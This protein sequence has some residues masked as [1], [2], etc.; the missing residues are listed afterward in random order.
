MPETT[1]KR[2]WSHLVWKK[3]ISKIDI[4]IG[5]HPDADHIGGLDD[6]IEA[7]EIGEFYLPRKSHTT[8]TFE[9]VLLAAKSNLSI[10]EGYDDRELDYDE[11][12]KLKIYLL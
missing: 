12:I 5:T 11:N 7:F 10:K 4:L 6:V 2:K 9:S 1:A 8:N 3:G